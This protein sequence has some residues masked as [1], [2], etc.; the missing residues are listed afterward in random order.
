MEKARAAI[1]A[2]VATLTNRHG[3]PLPIE[4][5]NQHYLDRI[6]RLRY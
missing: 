1:A 3:Q 2:S 6:A 4:I 5:R